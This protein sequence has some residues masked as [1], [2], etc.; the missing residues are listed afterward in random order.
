MVGEYDF[1]PTGSMKLMFPLL[2]VA[3]RKDVAK[4]S[5]KLQGGYCEG[6]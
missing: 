3:I 1:R 6:G 4:Q 5:Q 2:Q